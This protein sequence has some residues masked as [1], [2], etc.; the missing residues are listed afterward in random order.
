MVFALDADLPHEP[1]VQ[2]TFIPVVD[3]TFQELSETST[4]LFDSQYAETFECDVGQLELIS[5]VDPL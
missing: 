2:N 4:P 5:E 1:T 3:V